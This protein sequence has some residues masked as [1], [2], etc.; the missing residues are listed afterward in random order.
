MSLS[1]R[2]WVPPPAAVATPLA[3]LCVALLVSRALR[4][5]RRKPFGAS[6]TLFLGPDLGTTS[7]KSAVVR[8]T[9]SP[10]SLRVVGEVC[11]PRRAA[12]LPRDADA[13]GA[14]GTSFHEDGMGT[15]CANNTTQAI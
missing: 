7:I 3:A 6:R 15:L 13:G 11:L 2:R 1:A 9:G 14:F 5:R 4:I 8:V 10:P 12:T